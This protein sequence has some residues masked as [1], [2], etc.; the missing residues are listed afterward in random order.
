MLP[1]AVWHGPVVKA[2][3]KERSPAV[4]APAATGPAAKRYCLMME[5]ESNLR[6]CSSS[7]SRGCEA[8]RAEPAGTNTLSLPAVWDRH[9]GAAAARVAGGHHRLWKTPK[10]LVHFVPSGQLEVY[11]SEDSHCKNFLFFTIAQPLLC[12]WERWS[13]GAFSSRGMSGVCQEGYQELSLLLS[14]RASRLA[15]VL[16]CQQLQLL[17]T[18]VSPRSSW[19]PP[20][21]RTRVCEWINTYIYVQ[22]R[23]STVAAGHGEKTVDFSAL[24]P[25]LFGLQVPRKSMWAGRRLGAA[26]LPAA[27]SSP[28]PTGDEQPWRPPLA[29]PHRTGLPVSL[30]VGTCCHQEGRHRV[31]P[32]STPMR[33]WGATFSSSPWRSP[34]SSHL[35][36]LGVRNFPPTL[37]HCT[38]FLC[39]SC[40]HPSLMVGRTSGEKSNQAWLSTAAPSSFT[41]SPQLPLSP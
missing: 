20:Q 32:R 40:L 12:S 1:A 8:T 16:F 3:R 2:T 7:V 18:S 9:G 11:V 26:L 25:Q 15:P 38:D 33:M 14:G 29:S 39:C 37:C 30:P 4:P 35:A 34:V 22:R 17:E 31:H 6:G 19:Q 5:Q 24:L 21:Q 13:Q 10:S 23:Y 28:L 36:P 27:A 41:P